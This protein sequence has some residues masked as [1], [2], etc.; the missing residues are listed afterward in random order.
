[1]ESMTAALAFTIQDVGAEGGILVSPLGLQAGAKKVASK[2]NI[3]EVVL[4]ENSTT[5]SYMM[6][7]L[8]QI[9]MGDE[10]RLELTDHLLIEVRDLDGN[11]VERCEI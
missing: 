10:A 3:K 1:M 8:D 5:T 4:T 7:F 9:H 6:Q 11:V 2:A